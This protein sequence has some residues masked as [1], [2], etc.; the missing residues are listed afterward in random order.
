MP[1]KFTTEILAAAL[2]G[3]EAQKTRL[4]TKI[5]VLRTM[6]SGGPKKEAT[7]K[8]EAPKRKKRRL[9]AAGRQAIIDAAK[10]R[11][12]MIRAEKEKASQVAAPKKTAPKKAAAKPAPVKKAAKKKL[13]ARKKTASAPA[14]AE[15]TV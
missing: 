14:A 13:A 10:R 5:N 8:P 4:D 1:A 15:A 11:W 6:L 9:S 12:A 7:A 3:F 2:E